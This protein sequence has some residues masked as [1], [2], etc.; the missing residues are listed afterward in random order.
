MISLG[1]SATFG[2]QAPSQSGECKGL[3]SKQTHKNECLDD[4]RRRVDLERL[5]NDAPER[6]AARRKVSREYAARRERSD[7]R[8]SEFGFSGSSGK[9]P[10]ADEEVVDDSRAVE[11]GRQLGRKG[12]REVMKEGSLEHGSALFEGSSHARDE[13]VAQ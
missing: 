7:A 2:R 6:V 10:R 4:E 12:K 11:A 1:I 5:D 13:N 9:T 3:Q 8:T